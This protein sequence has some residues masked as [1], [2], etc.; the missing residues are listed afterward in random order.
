MASSAPG[1]GIDGIISQLDQF[2]GAGCPL[3]LPDGI[4]EFLVKFGPWITLVVLIISIPA[5]LAALGFGTI[6]SPFL[7]P[8]VAGFGLAWLLG[9]VQ[10][11]ITAVA[12]PGLSGLAMRQHNSFRWAWGGFC[13]V[14]PRA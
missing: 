2:F 8:K 1:G 4:R 12:L 5:M 9:A 10:T 6:L 7:G 13:L 3:Q 14:M 11:A